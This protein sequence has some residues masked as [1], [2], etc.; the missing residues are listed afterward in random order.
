MESAN[1]TSSV[2]LAQCPYFRGL[3]QTNKA[4]QV[5]NLKPKYAVCS[6]L[7]QWLYTGNFT[8]DPQWL[9][10]LYI[11][12]QVYQLPELAKVCKERLDQDV[13]GTN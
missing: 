10:E 8:V 13:P 11:V 1:E 5:L 12:A 7:I 4:A 3:F 9:E 2:I 6:A